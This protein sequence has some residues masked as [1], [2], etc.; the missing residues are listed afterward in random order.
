MRVVGGQ[1]RGDRTAAPGQKGT[2]QQGVPAVVAAPDQEEDV[3]AGHTPRVTAQLA[4][5]RERERVSGEVHVA[6]R[7]GG[8]GALRPGDGLGA[9]G[10]GR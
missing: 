5:G 4:Y 3:A 7:G 2:R 10:S 9:V 8:Q 6:V 1:C